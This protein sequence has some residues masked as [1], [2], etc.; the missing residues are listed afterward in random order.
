MQYGG[1]IVWGRFTVSRPGPEILL[2]K[3]NPKGMTV[4]EKE[5]HCWEKPRKN[6][7]RVKTDI[8]E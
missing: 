8:L 2:S 5:I 4:T 1:V 7:K 6:Q 3:R